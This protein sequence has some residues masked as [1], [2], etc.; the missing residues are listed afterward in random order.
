MI[1]SNDHLT[2]YYN[3]I[4]KINKHIHIK[5]AKTKNPQRAAL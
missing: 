4:M 5:K 2:S 1:K 3:T